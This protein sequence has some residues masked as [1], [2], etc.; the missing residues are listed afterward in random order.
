MPFF[1]DLPPATKHVERTHIQYNRD[2]KDSAKVS[3]INTLKLDEDLMETVYLSERFDAL[4]KA[5]KNNTFFESSMSRIIEDPNFQAILAMEEKAVPFIINEIEKEP[6]VLVWA[7]N[8]ITERSVESRQRLT[9]TEA[10]K[11]WVKDFNQ[12]K[13]QFRGINN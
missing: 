2:D 1:V 7:L 3:D 6:S 12:N 13:I 9:V 8:M 4:V 5:W 10:C 11:R